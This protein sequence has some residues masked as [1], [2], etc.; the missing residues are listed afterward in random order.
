VDDQQVPVRQLVELDA[1][2][3]TWIVATPKIKPIKLQ[4]L[5]QPALRRHRVPNRPSLQPDEIRTTI[6]APQLD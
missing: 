3:P 6:P 4:D 2:Q 1:M 5:A